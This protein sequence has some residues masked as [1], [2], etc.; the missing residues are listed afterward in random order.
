M[1]ASLWMLGIWHMLFL[2]L[3]ASRIGLH[4]QAAGP[5]LGEG[6]RVLVLEGLGLDP[7]P[8]TQYLCGFG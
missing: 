3:P 7:G 4:A 6:I 1:I 2:C 5:S 8:T